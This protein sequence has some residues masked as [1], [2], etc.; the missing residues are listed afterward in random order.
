MQHVEEFN[1]PLS[2]HLPDLPPIPT[3]EP[4]IRTFF[5]RIYPLFPVVEQATLMAD[6]VR[7][8]ELQSASVSGL[9]GA[10][11]HSDIATL[12]TIYSVISIG[13]DE[14]ERGIT[15]FGSSFLQGAYTLVGHLLSAPYLGSVQALLVL[16][17]ALRGRGK[18]LFP[19]V[20]N[21]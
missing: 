12:A 15:D 8:A 19:T 5:E 13:N 16:A 14:Y 6:L 21:K 10:I 3:L 9:Q 2:F 11:S 20:D 17:I 7:L 18:Y 1:L 4:A